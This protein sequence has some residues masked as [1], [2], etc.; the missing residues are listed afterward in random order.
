[1]KAL[2]KLLLVS[3]LIGIST[4][5][6]ATKYK[7]KG[8][9]EVSFYQTTTIKVTCK[10]DDFFNT[11]DNKALIDSVIVGTFVE[12]NYFEPQTD[13]LFGEFQT[14]VETKVKEIIPCIDFRITVMSFLK[15]ICPP[16]D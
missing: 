14:R 7:Y 11:P 15:S 3:I 9:F 4:S 6:F 1:M 13:N 8:K 5:C 12:M 16:C 2:I 10:F